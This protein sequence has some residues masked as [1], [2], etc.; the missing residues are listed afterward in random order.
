MSDQR[1]PSKPR[2]SSDQP[3]ISAPIANAS[4]QDGL[5]AVV[6]I[7]VPSARPS[8]S[9]SAGGSAGRAAAIQHL[10]LADG[11]LTG[12]VACSTDDRQRPAASPH[13]A[14]A[15]QQGM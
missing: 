15:H 6:D 14:H 12:G 8:V 3:D 2:N 13:V 11:D 4:R 7:A 9:A 5:A 10:D 1:P